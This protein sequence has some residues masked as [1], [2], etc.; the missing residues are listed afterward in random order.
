MSFLHYTSTVFFDSYQERNELS[1]PT[2]QDAEGRKPPAPGPAPAIASAVA[3][4]SDN[5]RAT[6]RSS[7]LDPPAAISST[8]SAGNNTSLSSTSDA[9]M[10]PDNSEDEAGVP[11][12]A[13]VAI[14]ARTARENAARKSAAA[15]EAAAAKAAAEEEEGGELSAL[16]DF[17]APSG[18]GRP[19]MAPF[20]VSDTSDVWEMDGPFSPDDGKSIPKAR[21]RVGSTSGVGGASGAAGGRNGR[22]SASVVGEIEGGMGG[23]L[24]HDTDDT[25]SF[26]SHDSGFGAATLNCVKGIDGKGPSLER[27]RQ[28]GSFGDSYVWGGGKLVSAALGGGGASSGAIVIDA[29][30][31]WSCRMVSSKQ[32]FE[33]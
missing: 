28:N 12:V 26:V 27:G 16:G 15:A 6:P 31:E 24:L 20:S 13:A 18:V 4:G 14:A 23:H 2:V 19:A 29:I 30:G 5:R 9:G 21:A 7:S 33:V 1:A 17:V 10:E 3:S 32:I 11:A 25:E 8:D 22:G